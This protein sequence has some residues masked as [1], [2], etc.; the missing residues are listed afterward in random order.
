MTPAPQRAGVEERVPAPMFP[1]MSKL[2]LEFSLER[3]AGHLD[4]PAPFW[5]IGDDGGY[6]YCPDCI[7]AAAK[8][9]NTE[10][11]GG[12]Q[13]GEHDSCEHCEVCGALLWYSLTDYGAQQ[14]LDHFRTVRFGRPPDPE[15]LYHIERMLSAMLEDGPHFA[16]ARAI[17]EQ[18]LLAVTRG[19]L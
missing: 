6:S 12:F 16:E 4:P 5:L 1:Y 13:G 15:T 19:Q 18:A 17:A 7:D 10:I 2:D 9:R 8:G 3:L 11:D 14:E